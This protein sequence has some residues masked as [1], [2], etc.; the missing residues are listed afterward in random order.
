MVIVRNNTGHSEQILVKIEGEVLHPGYYSLTNKSE[1]VSDLIKRAGGL[2]PL[3]YQQ[4]ASLKRVGAEN[5]T[6]K[7]QIDYTDNNKTK[8]INLQR[9]QANLKD[10]TNAAQEISIN[11]TV[12]INLVEILKHPGGKNDVILKA[13]DV[14]KIPQDLQTIKINGEILYPVTVLYSD[15][16][17]FKYYI[18]Q[19]GGYTQKALR[20]SSYVV[21]ANGAV[22]N[23]RKFLFFTHYPIIQ[24]G[25]EIFVPRKGET[26]R[27]S[28][29]EFV[30]IST[31]VASLG[32]IILGVL[33]L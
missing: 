11:N 22:D 13:G 15:G 17:S 10:S 23:V 12:G 16:E 29:L 14:L 7:N 9:L 24:P 1:K 18:S 20:H 6:G 27:A 33:K 26:K 19:A 8:L 32:A 28:A 21:Y 31:A 3:A 30:S 5:G 2:T 4:G 25:S